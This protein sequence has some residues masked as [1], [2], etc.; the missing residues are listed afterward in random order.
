M[1]ASPL[2]KAVENKTE[3]LWRSYISEKL[4][5]KTPELL[6]CL[7][8]KRSTAPL[9]QSQP[10]RACEIVFKC[11]EKSFRKPAV[12]DAV[13]ALVFHVERSF[14]E[15]RRADD[16]P[17]AVDDRRLGVHHRRLVFV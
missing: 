10:L 13:V 9:I 11:H 1:K 5:E 2:G 12:A 6:V 3:S 14:V 17:P 4:A 7:L 15:I 8:M 16:A